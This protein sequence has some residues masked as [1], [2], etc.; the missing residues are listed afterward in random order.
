MQAKLNEALELQGY[1][2]KMAEDY[3]AKFLA[4]DREHQMLK[5]THELDIENLQQEHKKKSNQVADRHQF[6]QLEATR[7]MEQATNER[8]Q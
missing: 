2:Q 6:E 1:Y 7:K 4:L 5:H 3:R 8:D